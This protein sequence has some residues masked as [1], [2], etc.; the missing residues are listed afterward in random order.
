MISVYAD[1]SSTGRSHREGGWAYV[2][3]KNGAPLYSDYGGS[4]STTNNLMEVQAAIEGLR[5]L[6]KVIDSIWVKGEEIE[7]VSDSRY[8][9]NMAAGLNTPNT[10]LEQV[11]ALRSLYLKLCTGFRWVP[12][13]KGDIFNERCDSLAKRGK[14]EAAA[15]MTKLTN[16]DK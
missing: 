9:L 16:G 4:A 14:D 2:I 6:E 13:H 12:G 11:R 15:T 1:G 3:C 5:G 10:N 7:L 8:C